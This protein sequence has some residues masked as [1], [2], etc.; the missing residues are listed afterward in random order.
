[1]HPLFEMA[2]HVQAKPSPVAPP[3]EP[4]VHEAPPPAEPS[5]TLMVHVD[6]DH[7][8]PAPSPAPMAPE[9]V[10]LEEQPHLR[11][12]M[13]E[14]RAVVQD[15]RA[16]IKK[17]AQQLNQQRADIVHDAKRMLS[18]AQQKIAQQRKQLRSAL[19]HP[20]ARL[21]NQLRR[22]KQKILELM[23]EKR[24]R[25]GLQRRVQRQEHKQK[26]QLRMQQIVQQRNAQA[27]AANMY[28]T[29]VKLAAAME[30]RQK[31]AASMQA[32]LLEE[33]QLRAGLLSPTAASL[34]AGTMMPG[35]IGLSQVDPSLALAAQAQSLALQPQ[36]APMAMPAQ[37]SPFLQQPFGQLADSE[38]LEPPPVGLDAML[39][40]QQDA[41]P[42]SV[43][44]AAASSFQATLASQ[45]KAQQAATDDAL[46]HPLKSLT[47]Q[48]EVLLA[49]KA[50][51][52]QH[53][54]HKQPKQPKPVAAKDLVQLQRFSPKQ[55]W[56]PMQLASRSAADYRQQF[57]QGQAAVSPLDDVMLESGD[58]EKEAGEDEGQKMAEDLLKPAS[59]EE[60][61]DVV[62]AAL[63]AAREEVEVYEDADEEQEES[64][65]QFVLEDMDVPDSPIDD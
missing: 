16:V 24:R 19:Q 38:P 17:Q 59:E 34:P 6:W 39:P 43:A 15:Q 3:P 31:V 37:P 5:T 64:G 46:K 25:L 18:A 51:Q 21:E 48:P 41:L 11:R 28:A 53:K 23:G 26:Q 42:P 4:K 62:S 44:Q 57:Q 8:E 2:S 65:T 45:A 32:S 1:M 35:A 22:A 20:N 10:L 29:R 55:Q 7:M 52:E 54:Q 9:E 58:P 36:V 13:E 14:Q 12:A 30:R 40:E 50:M 61:T 63:E 60:D 47:V 56:A 49:Q 27:Q 33:Q